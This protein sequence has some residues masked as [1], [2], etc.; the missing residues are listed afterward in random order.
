MPRSQAHCIPMRTGQEGSAS[1]KTHTEPGPP[2]T[3]IP[4]LSPPRSLSYQE[5]IEEVV[6]KI[7]S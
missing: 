4:P 7:P 1:E 3:L 2:R 6:L 5:N